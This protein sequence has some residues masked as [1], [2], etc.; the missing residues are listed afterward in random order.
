MAARR[1]VGWALFAAALVLGSMPAHAES[2]HERLWNRFAEDVFAL[3]QRQLAGRDVEERSRVG[4]YAG[5]PEFY[6][7]VEYSDAGSGALLSRIRWVREQPGTI[8]VIEVFVRDGQGRIVRDYTAAWLPE[9]RKAPS[10]TLVS[11]HSYTGGLHAFRMFDAS[12]DR[13]YER[14]EGEYRG[15]SLRLEVDQEMFYDARLDPGPIFESEEYRRCFDGLPT[16]ADAF[17]PPR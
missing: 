1:F 13:L 12:G 8:D 11:L 10:Q 3:H 14:C 2:A 17:L 4:G 15:E 6:R 5:R 16:T 9:Y 7:E